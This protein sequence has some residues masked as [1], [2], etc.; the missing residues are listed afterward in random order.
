MITTAT[1]W[2][3]RKK[4]QKRPFNWVETTPAGTVVGW[5]DEHHVYYHLGMVVPLRRS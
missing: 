4:T 5:V 1:I 3:W 2:R